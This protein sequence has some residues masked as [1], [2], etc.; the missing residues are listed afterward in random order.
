MKMT[1][2][3]I[4]RAHSFYK[5]ILKYLWV[6]GCEVGNLLQNNPGGNND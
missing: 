4:K 6:K 3:Q 1:M 2:F 5:Y